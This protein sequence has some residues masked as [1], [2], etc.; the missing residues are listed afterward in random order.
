[1]SVDEKDGVPALRC[2]AE[3]ALHRVRDTKAVQPYFFASPSVSI[4]LRSDSVTSTT[5]FL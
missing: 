2:T 3:E 5:N 4:T 1:M